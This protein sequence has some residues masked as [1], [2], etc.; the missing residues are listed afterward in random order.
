MF[1]SI[2]SEEAFSV[3]MD[4]VVRSFRNPDFGFP[5]DFVDVFHQRTTVQEGCHE[6][7]SRVAFCKQVFQFC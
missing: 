6:H 7:Q 1:V 5:C 2:R 4:Y 3:E